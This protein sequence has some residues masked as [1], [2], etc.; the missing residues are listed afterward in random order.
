MSNISLVFTMLLLMLCPFG[1]L[2][3]LNGELIIN[4]QT[5]DEDWILAFEKEAKDF[6]GFPTNGLC[7]ERDD[8]YIVEALAAAI[9]PVQEANKRGMDITE[10]QK[11]KLAN[12]LNDERYSIEFNQAIHVT[13]RGRFFS[14]LFIEPVSDEDIVEEYD[15]LIESEDR[16]VVN[17]LLYKVDDYDFREEEADLIYEAAVAGKDPLPIALGMLE[18][19]YKENFL[20]GLARDEWTD[21]S[22]RKGVSKEDNEYF[23]GD[24]LRQ[25][26]SPPWHLVSVIQEIKII[27][28]RELN[29][30]HPTSWGTK[31]DS[32]RG[33]IHRDRFKQFARELRETADITLAGQKVNL[34]DF[35]KLYRWGEYREKEWLAHCHSIFSAP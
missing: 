11:A 22:K 6:D 13:V 7:V 29:K 2:R 15:R 20:S 25:P 14:N 21:S 23:V 30:K 26:L 12:Y 33:E 18:D 5:V 35:D 28:T 19:R 8:H 10:S 31:F 16:T 3:A 27:P 1:D 24:V 32:L 9:L 17:V 34:P 4:G